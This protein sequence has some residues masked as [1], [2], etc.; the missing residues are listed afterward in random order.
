[1]KL[2][3][4]KNE[5]ALEL[6]ADIIEPAMD[7]LKDKKIRNVFS[8]KKFNKLDTV[9]YLLKNHKE[10][11]VKIMAALDGTPYEEYEFNIISGTAQ[12][13]ELL[14]DEELLRFFQSQGQMLKG[15]SS[16]SATESTTETEK[17]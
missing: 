3:D 17:K 8:G 14:N 15:K 9:K 16:G 6:L 2:T 5:E 10:S 4:Y 12:V 11:I 13:M 7:I 1:M